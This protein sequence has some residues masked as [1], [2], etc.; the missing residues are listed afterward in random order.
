MLDE[1]IVVVVQYAFS[2]FIFGVIWQKWKQEDKQNN[3]ESFWVIKHY[4]RKLKK[5]RDEP[6]LPKKEPVA[7]EEWVLKNDSP[8]PKSGQKPVTILD[9]KNGWVR[10]DMH[11]ICFRDERMKM[12]SFLY[13]Y[14]FHA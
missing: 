12:G 7:G 8:W 5:V 2:F 14:S 13:C 10:Y 6:I 4:W 1:K 9:V 3:R 11:G